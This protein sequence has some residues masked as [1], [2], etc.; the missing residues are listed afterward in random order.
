MTRFYGEELL[1]PSPAPKLENHALSALRDRLFYI[2][3]ATFHIGGHFTMRNLMTRHG[4]VRWTNFMDCW[5]ETVQDFPLRPS[6][7]AMRICSVVMFL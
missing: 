2:F 3:E 5:T 4:V 7:Y 1:A 6:Q